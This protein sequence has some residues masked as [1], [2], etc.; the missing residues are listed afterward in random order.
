MISLEDGTVTVL[1]DEDI[2]LDGENGL[3]PDLVKPWP[4]RMF[5]EVT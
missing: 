1:V 5:L 2:G 4:R 3:Y